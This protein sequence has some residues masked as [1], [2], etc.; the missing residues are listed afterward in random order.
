MP[1]SSIKHETVHVRAAGTEKHLR[2]SGALLRLEG[3]RCVEI[4]LEQ[5]VLTNGASEG[6]A[7]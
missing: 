6:G 2:E 3:L 1:T 4:C 5:L 7:R